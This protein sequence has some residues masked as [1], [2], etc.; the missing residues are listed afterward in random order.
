M[1]EIKGRI[2]DDVYVCAV[3]AVDELAAVQCTRE[4]YRVV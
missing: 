4:D 3:M 1:V 2:L